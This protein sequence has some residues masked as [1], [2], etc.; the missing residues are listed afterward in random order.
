MAIRSRFAVSLWHYATW[1]KFP[2]WLCRIFKSICPSFQ[3][4]FFSSFGHQSKF[5][6]TFSLWYILL[7]ERIFENDVFPS[8]EKLKRNYTMG[9]DRIPI[10]LIEDCGSALS[11]PLTFLY[12]SALKTCFSFSE[13]KQNCYHSQ[14]GDKC[15]FETYLFMGMWDIS[16]LNINIAL[17]KSVLFQQILC[18]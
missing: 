4:K 6:F 17:R 10:F 3:R 5:F 14:N 7:C 9:P 11:F 8:F 13:T 2:R 16:F 18:I 15:F 1:W 12:N